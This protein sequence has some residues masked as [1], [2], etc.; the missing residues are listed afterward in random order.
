MQN[1]TILLNEG[2]TAELL[3]V[4]TKCLQAWWV[5]GGGPTYLKIGRLV[6]Y[7]QTDLDAFLAGCR[8]ENTTSGPV[9]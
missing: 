8:R 7:S 2:Q 3:N 9:K 5:R 4:T 6:K 1:H